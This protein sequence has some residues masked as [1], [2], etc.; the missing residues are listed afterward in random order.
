MKN[1]FE[2]FKLKLFG[3]IYFLSVVLI[4]LL[5]LRGFRSVFGLAISRAASNVKSRFVVRSKTRKKLL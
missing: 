4:Y 3:V 1:T 5:T 2:Y